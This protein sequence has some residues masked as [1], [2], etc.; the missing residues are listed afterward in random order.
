MPRRKIFVFILIV[1]IVSIATFGVFRIYSN[2][3]NTRDDTNQASRSNLPNTKLSINAHVFNVELATTSAERTAGLSGRQ[4]LADDGG[5]LFVDDD[6]QLQYFWMKDTLIPLD[7]IWID[8]S[9]RIVHI[10]ADVQPESYPKSFGPDQP[11][12]Y[13][14]ELKGG[15]VWRQNIKVGDAV[16]FDLP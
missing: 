11:T 14:L 8:D 16:K 9:K 7:I 15:T 2:Q 10:D 1:L 4:S 5:M 6:K 12:P 3:I 13:V